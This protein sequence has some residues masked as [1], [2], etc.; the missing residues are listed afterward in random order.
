MHLLELFCIFAK[1]NTMNEIILFVS[2]CA[3]FAYVW[4]NILI[5]PQMIF[6]W[7]G[8][9]IDRLPMYLSKPL[10]GCSLCFGGQF[11]LWAYIIYFQ[12][13][14]FTHFA[15]VIWTIFLVYVLEQLKTHL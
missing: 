15:V 6:G 8:D 12:Y 9:R 2:T 13:D 4:S 11:S 10:G 7:Y 1:T 14:L 3:V 5:Q